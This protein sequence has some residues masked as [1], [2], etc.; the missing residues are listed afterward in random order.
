HTTFSR[1]WSSDVCSSD[2]KN[3]FFTSSGSVKPSDPIHLTWEKSKPH[4]TTSGE[5]SI[6]FSGEELLKA[7]RPIKRIGIKRSC[8]FIGSSVYENTL[9]FSS[10]LIILSRILKMP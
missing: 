4:Q 8:F 9:C 2:L 7:N 1:D 6:S 10:N 3:L 5:S